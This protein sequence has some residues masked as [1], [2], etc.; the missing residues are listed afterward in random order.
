MSPSDSYF[1]CDRPRIHLNGVWSLR[2]LTSVPAFA[3]KRTTRDTADD[4]LYENCLFWYVRDVC[5]TRGGVQERA[6]GGGMIGGCGGGGRI[7]AVRGE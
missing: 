5:V 2:L 4:L 6:E 3:Q 1:A 7:S